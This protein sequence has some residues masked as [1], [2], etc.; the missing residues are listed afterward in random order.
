[1][2]DN[3]I[4]SKWSEKKFQNKMGRKWTNYKYVESKKWKNARKEVEREVKGATEKAK[5]LEH[6]KK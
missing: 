5:K 1:M 3:A 4:K 6:E 2:I